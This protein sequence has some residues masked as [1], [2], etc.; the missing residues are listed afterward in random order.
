MII[1]EQLEGTPNQQVSPF[2]DLT[3]GS[4]IYDPQAQGEPYE[5]FS[6][7]GKITLFFPKILF[8][9]SKG[10]LTIQWDGI[11]MRYQADRKF[12]SLESGRINT[13]ELT[14]IMPQDAI[15]NY[16]K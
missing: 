10:V 7:P 4:E 3:I 9:N 2:S 14:E 6:F 8:S 15:V 16:F 5:Q 12:P 1:R 13:L 11:K